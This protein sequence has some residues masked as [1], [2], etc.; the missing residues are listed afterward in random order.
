MQGGVHLLTGLLLASF[1]KR[2][3]Y[4]LGA[5]LGAILPDFDIFIMAFVYLFIGEKASVVHRS[6]TH[7][8]L[9]LIV[10]P[11]IVVSLNF[12]PKIKNKKNYDFLGLGIGLFFGLAVHILIDMMY[13]TGVYFL[14][15]FS[16]QDIGFPIVAFA[17]IDQGIA[18]NVLKLKLI[19]TTDFYTDIF[20]FFI[21]VLV[22]AY[23]MDVHKKIR[24]PILV[25][26]VVDFLVTTVFVG[27]AFNTNISYVDHV[28]YLYYLG[29][30]FLLLSVIAPILFRN[31]IREFKFN[32]GEMSIMIGLLIFSQF[33][34]YF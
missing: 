7:S 29:T 15:P 1:S 27:L 13:L 20:F 5:V 17:N 8:L 2:K 25:I 34:L 26:V 30:F 11:G 28:I 33:L 4:K 6:L 23:K 9:F 21:P 22:L 16:S 31:V 3:E 14:W 24:L 19:Q 18:S 12:I 32:I 10:V